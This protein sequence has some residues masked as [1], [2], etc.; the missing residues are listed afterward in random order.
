[1]RTDKRIPLPTWL[2]WLTAAS[3]MLT[4]GSTVWLDRHHYNVL[5]LVATGISAG[6]FLLMLIQRLTGRR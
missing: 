1:M 2:I 4:F 3:T 6:V 5:L